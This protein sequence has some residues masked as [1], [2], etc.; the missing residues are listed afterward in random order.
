MILILWKKKI[1]WQNYLI[2][3]DW[4]LFHVQDENR[5]INSN[6]AGMGQP[7]VWTILTVIGKEGYSSNAL[8]VCTRRALWQGLFNVQSLAFFL[9]EISYFTSLQSLALF[10]HGIS[11][12]TSLSD[13]L[14]RS[15]TTNGLFQILYHGYPHG[16]LHVFDHWNEHNAS[17][18]LLQCI[19]GVNQCHWTSLSF[20]SPWLEFQ[21]RQNVRERI[22][23][24]PDFLLL[25]L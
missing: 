24:Y 20:Y 19:F 9:H 4:L 23:V 17:C 15:R 13:G 7:I 3:F 11:Y 12:F 14:W 22:L 1:S 25:L 21:S 6:N 10:L 2:H 16:F 5:L 8:Q 18:G